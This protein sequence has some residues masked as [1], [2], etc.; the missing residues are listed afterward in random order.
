[1]HHHC[2]LSKSADRLHLVYCAGV[3]LQVY[4]GALQKYVNHW[5]I[6]IGFD[7]DTP[8]QHNVSQCVGDTAKIACRLCSFNASTVPQPIDADGKRPKA[9]TKWLGYSQCVPTRVPQEEAQKSIRMLPDVTESC[10][11][12][13]LRLRW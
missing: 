3:P 1:M 13:D 4:D 5:P 11:A 6:L 10:L 2:T 9:L 12:T 8:M 7:G